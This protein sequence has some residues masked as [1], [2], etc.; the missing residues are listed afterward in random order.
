MLDVYCFDQE[1]NMALKQLVSKWVCDA[2]D[3]IWLKTNK[4]ILL[5]NFK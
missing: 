1:F 4:L 3:A 5:Q 2:V